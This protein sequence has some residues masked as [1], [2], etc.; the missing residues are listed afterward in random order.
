MKIIVWDDD[1][2]PTE[3]SLERLGKI[4][5]GDD[6][7]KAYEAFWSALKEN[8]YGNMMYGHTKVEVR[9]EI[10]EVWQYHTGGWSGNESIIRVLQDTVYWHLVLDRYDA[11]GH[12]YFKLPKSEDTK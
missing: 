1:G 12:Y 11:G 8:T 6:Y 9:G 3:E 5:N 4:L 7:E 10:K 2:Y